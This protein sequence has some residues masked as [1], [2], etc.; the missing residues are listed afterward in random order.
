MAGPAGHQPPAG[1]ASR[2]DAVLLLTMGGP[3]TAAEIEPFL[4]QMLQD[5]L[6]IPIPGPRAVRRLFA[7]LVSWRRAPRAARH[8]A[9]L[10]GGSPLNGITRRQAKA[11]EA[12]LHAGGGRWLVRPC[13]RYL[14]AETSRLLAEIAAW[15]PDRLIL[16]PMYPFFS[17]S[18]TRSAFEHARREWLRLAPDSRL[19]ILE[20]PSW[21]DF[22]PYLDW[23]AARTLEAWH[24][25]PP[26]AGPGMVLFSVHGLPESFVRRGD[27]YPRDVALAEAGLRERLEAIPVH[28]G[29]QS[30]FG[31]GKW[32][33]PSTLARIQQLAEAGGR[34][35]VLVP[36]GFPAENLETA[37]ELDHLLA[38]AARQAGFPE[39]VRVPC[40]DADPAFIRGLAELVRTAAPAGNRDPV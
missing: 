30:K 4:C 37:Y 35:L 15:R 29:F 36:L 6:L 14:P 7:R 21:P 12:E 27:P 1:D 9:L 25:L 10:G 22:P 13:F 8:Y 34:Q 38:P 33:A 16:L 28:V 20:I 17:F 39:V 18:T 19:S 24:R 11:L 31:P 40:P 5:P 26:E 3:E 23:L 2:R 32:L